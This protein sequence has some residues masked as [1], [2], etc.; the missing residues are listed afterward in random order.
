MHFGTTIR[1]LET[2]N[3]ITDPTQIYPGEALQIPA[4]A[5]SAAAVPVAPART[6]TVQRGDTVLSIARRFSV[7][8]DALMTA[9][10]LANP[11]LIR[12]GQQLQIP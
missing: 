11:D 10:G 8:A 9:N 2:L 7:S 5:G 3:N 6:Y 4:G 1:V 12:V